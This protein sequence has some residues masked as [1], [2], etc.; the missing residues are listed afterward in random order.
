[1]GALRNLLQ[2]RLWH[3]G[4]RF[5]VF[6]VIW[7]LWPGEPDLISPRLSIYVATTSREFCSEELV[8]PRP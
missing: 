4:P 5:G 1:M 8:G 3:R 7:K 6:R 2:I